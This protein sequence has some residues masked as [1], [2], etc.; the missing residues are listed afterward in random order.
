MARWTGSHAFLDAEALLAMRAIPSMRLP[1]SRISSPWPRAF[2]LSD[3][4]FGD[5]PTASWG[6]HIAS[7][8]ATMDGFT[9]YGSPQPG[10]KGVLGPGW[11]CDSGDD[12][13]WKSPD[14]VVMNMPSCV[15]DP[16]LNPSLYPHGRRVPVNLCCSCG[17][18]HG[19]ARL[20]GLSWRIYGGLGG[21]RQQPGLRLVDLSDVRRV[22]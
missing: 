20:A 12:A 21:H 7:V 8:A 5:G 13:P 19:R 14:G 2:A 22:H 11:G 4:T 15:P 9:G 1:L 18:D 16:S 17:D 10:S 6:M 3:R